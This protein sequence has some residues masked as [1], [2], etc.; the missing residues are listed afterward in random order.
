MQLFINNSYIY[1]YMHGTHSK[2]VIYL[3]SAS[4]SFACMG[5]NS[6]NISKVWMFCVLHITNDTSDQMKNSSVRHARGDKKNCEI[7]L[8]MY[9]V[10]R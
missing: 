9:T 5:V 4:L 1:Y 10:Y 2:S 8:Y 3:A 7:I 6:F